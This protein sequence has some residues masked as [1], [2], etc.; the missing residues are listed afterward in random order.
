[1]TRKFPV[2]EWGGPSPRKR[3]CNEER[4]KAEERNSQMSG[5][6]INFGGQFNID[7]RLLFDGDEDVI[8]YPAL[9]WSNGAFPDNS[10]QVLHSS[11]ELLRPNCNGREVERERGIPPLCQDEREA[12]IGRK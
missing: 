1:M 3:S 6:P 9:D 7:P 4:R 11:D 12:E 5:Q 10:E 8:D 2:S